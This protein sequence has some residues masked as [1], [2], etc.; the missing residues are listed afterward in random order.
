MIAS[1]DAT[2]L[3]LL[4]DPS[5]KAPTDPQ[6]GNPVPDCQERI[7]HLIETIAKTRGARMFFPAPALAEF[8]VRVEAG[9]VAEFVSQ[10]QRLRG[11]EIRAFDTRAAIE[12]A[13]MQRAVIFE[14]RRRVPKGELESRA[15]AKFDQQIVAISKAAGATKIFT[16]DAGLAAFAARFA[17]EAIGVAQLPLSPEKRQG[18]LPLEP[19]EPTD[20]RVE[21]E[22]GSDAD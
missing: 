8:F 22:K 7:G 9:S 2:M 3:I 15:K 10:I 21:G 16:D 18:V 17:I 14:R 4:F 5:A 13:E 11:G 1:F 20:L 19:P 12:F 6:T